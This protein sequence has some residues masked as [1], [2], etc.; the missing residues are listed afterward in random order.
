MENEVKRHDA[1]N[2]L[3]MVCAYLVIVIHLMAFQVFGDGARYVTSEFICRIAVPFFF[4]TAGYFFY[5]KVNKEGYFKK[6]IMKLIKVYVIATII[7]S[8]LYV[9]YLY[10][11]FVQGGL[12]YTLKVFFVNSIS[13]TMWYFPTLILSISIVYIFLKK[14]LIK[15]LMGISAILLLI[16]LMGDSYYGLIVNTPF[17]HIINAYDI[18]FDNTRNGITFGVPFITIGTLI[19]KYEL[20]E[21]IKKP[22]ILFVLF[23]IVF[24]IEAYFLMHTGIAKDYNIYFSTTLVVPMMLIMALNSKI[25]I[26]DKVSSYM[27]EMSL[28]IY[29][30]HSLLI[31]IISMVLRIAPQNSI[32]MYLLVCVVATL[33]ASII[34]KIKFRK[35]IFNP[36]VDSNIHQ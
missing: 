25:K 6:Y 22:E 20:N 18:I 1:V 29:V 13:G 24:G 15:P 3:R 31:T 30:Y 17:I 11:A 8:I 2:I 36:I 23:W 35:K 26:S 9:P 21:S 16:G 33:L 10:P 19:C 12:G 34:T 7:Y 27:R 4:I 32:L 5:R 28:W 14:N